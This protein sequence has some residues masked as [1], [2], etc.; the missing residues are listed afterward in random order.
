M[1]VRKRQIFLVVLLILAASLVLACNKKDDAKVLVAEIGKE[2]PDFSLTD[3]TG[4]TWKL[5]DLKG[6]VVFVNFWATWCEPC[7]EEMPSMEALHRSMDGKPFQML[8]ILSSDSAANA[9]MMIK[10]TGSTFPIPVDTDGNASSDY[11][12]TGVP[13]TFIIDPQG[14][15]REKFLG[16]RPWDS[17]G[18]QDMLKKYLP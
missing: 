3:L 5:S 6:K 14:I 1:I 4:K 16:P 13:E 11:G 15:L 18:A 17:Q 10:I 2:A 8:A 7:R 9:E 12:L